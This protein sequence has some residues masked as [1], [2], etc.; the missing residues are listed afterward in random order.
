MTVGWAADPPQLADARAAAERYREEV[1]GLQEAMHTTKQELDRETARAAAAEEAR[2]EVPLP[3]WRV[4]NNTNLRHGDA[5]SL[6][7]RL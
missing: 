7:F 3:G 1:R 5:T 6:D 2:A 4:A